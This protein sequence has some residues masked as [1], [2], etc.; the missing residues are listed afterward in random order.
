MVGP[1]EDELLLEAG[2]LAVLASPRLIPPCRYFHKTCDWS[3]FAGTRI[4][5]CSKLTMLYNQRSNELSILRELLSVEVVLR[6][7]EP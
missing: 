2:I 7:V 6:E 4:A 3:D 1:E 5:H